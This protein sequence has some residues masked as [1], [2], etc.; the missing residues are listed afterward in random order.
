M[1][2]HNILFAPLASFMISQ[3]PMRISLLLERE[4]FETILEQTL[5]RFWVRFY[6]QPY[7][8]RWQAG[9][10]GFRRGT[11]TRGEQRWLVNTY[12]NAIFVP[13]VDPTVLD[14]IRQEFSRS[15]IWWKRPLQQ[16]YVTAG[17]SRLAAPYLAQAS[18][19]IRPGI[20]DARQKLI[21][22]GNHKIRILNRRNGLSYGI[23]K[24]GFDD[25]FMRRELRYRRLADSL[26]IPSPPLLDISPQGDWFVERLVSG[27]PVN[28]LADKK[29]ARKAVAKAVSALKQLINH[30]MKVQ[31]LDSYLDSLISRLGSLIAENFLLSDRQK[32]ALRQQIERLQCSILRH[33]VSGI[34]DIPVAVTH[35]DFQAANILVGED[36]VWLIDWEYADWRHTTYDLLVYGLNARFPHG[37][38]SRLASF[39]DGRFFLQV[40]G[41][42]NLESW[43]GGGSKSQSERLQV[44]NLFLLEE[45]VLHLEENAQQPL[46]K[47]GA[48]LVSLQREIDRWLERLP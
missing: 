15:T 29:A 31:R 10:P 3:L 2:R 34:R 5:S 45:L 32:Q 38:A 30:T 6:G 14:P 36:N 28:R 1:L 4:P 41:L 42:A 19:E 20:E 46:T 43:L 40:P 13:D 16:V 8:V 21:I 47:V 18:L 48:G 7:S 37:L 17:L 9:C 35:G 25:R 44:V 24:H 33:V 12:L 11:A 22:A 27:T 39:V 23:L 26:G